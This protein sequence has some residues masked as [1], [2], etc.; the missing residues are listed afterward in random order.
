MG[1]GCVLCDFA[2]PYVGTTFVKPEVISVVPAARAAQFNG[3]AQVLL[4][5]GLD[6]MRGEVFQALKTA[7]GITQTDAT[8]QWGW[9]RD[10]AHDYRVK[11]SAQTSWH[12]WVS[13]VRVSIMVSRNTHVSPQ[14]REYVFV[15]NGS[16]GAHYG[17]WYNYYYGYYNSWRPTQL[18]AGYDTAL[19]VAISAAIQDLCGGGAPRIVGGGESM[20]LLRQAGM[21]APPTCYEYEQWTGLY[22]TWG[23]YGINS[24]WP[25]RPAYTPPAHH[26]HHGFGK[27][28]RGGR[29]GK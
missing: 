13:A 16:G 17:S 9:Q 19:R 11:V 5:W 2:R 10:S 24:H 21:C 1:D 14:R 26:H 20:I 27:G 25:S 12:H 7:C 8:D 22:G 3:S 28:S 23:G 29:R 4:D 18:Y 15:K 6:N